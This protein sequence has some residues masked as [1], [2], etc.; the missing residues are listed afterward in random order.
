MNARQLKEELKKFDENLPVRM[1]SRYSPGFT[2][3][4]PSF[5]DDNLILD[6]QDD[7]YGINTLFL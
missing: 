4:G 3:C 2:M 6:V 7:G 1:D 5:D